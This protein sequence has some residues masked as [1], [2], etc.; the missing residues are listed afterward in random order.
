MPRPKNKKINPSPFP[1]AQKKSQI[2]LQT[3]DDILARILYAGVCDSKSLF[4]ASLSS[5][6]VY[7]HLKNALTRNHVREDEYRESYGPRKRPHSYLSITADGLSYLRDRVYRASASPTQSDISLPFASMPWLLCLPTNVSRVL[8]FSG[9]RH[10]SVIAF[11]VRCGN[12][13]LFAKMMD[14]AVSEFT[15]TGR[16]AMFEPP[17]I[18]EDE[19]TQETET[20]SE[21]AK[22]WWEMI[23]DYSEDVNSIPDYEPDVIA[24]APYDLNDSFDP[25]VEPADDDLARNQSMSLG[26]IKREAVIRYAFNSGQTYSVPPHNL[27]FFPSQEIKKML[28]GKPEVAKL[29]DFS[30]SSYTGMLASKQ[31]SVVLYHARHDGIGW[32]D[33]NENKDIA[34]MRQFSLRCSPFDNFVYKNTNGA[35]L[36]YNEKNF[37]DIISNKFNRRRKG[38]T[39]G[40]F[41]DHLYLVPLSA[42]GAAMLKWV[43]FTPYTE[44]VSYTDNIIKTKSE[45]KRTIDNYQQSFRLKDGDTYIFD[46]TDM[47][48]KQILKAIAVMER[49][50]RPKFK[51]LCFE[52]QASFYRTVWPDVEA[53]F[54]DD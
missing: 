35:I 8:P 46:G 4:D 36:I 33:R 10:M 47:D 45:A 40:K 41:F 26:E 19:P 29:A 16:V 7:Y 12:S 51:I 28:M 3:Y 17:T 9:D 44:R 31:M 52:W 23:S 30:Y 24:D 1:S 38:S 43:M 34:T 39:L 27:Y 15:L 2:S 50:G 5:S 21:A 48:A 14:A 6:T 25:S 32:N 49:A 53:V 11:A 37:G 22:V 54:L 18:T 13:L 42:N 20:D